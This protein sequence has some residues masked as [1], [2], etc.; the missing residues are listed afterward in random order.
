MKKVIIHP[1]HNICCNDSYQG[2]PLEIDLIKATRDKTPIV[3]I[4]PEIFTLR[5]EGVRPDT[6][7]RVDKWDIAHAD[8]ERVSQMRVAK[9]DKDESNKADESKGENKNSENSEKVIQM[10]TKNPKSTGTE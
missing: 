3:S 9:L 4:S 10:D 1:N 5:K 6:D 2:S 7:I 8:M